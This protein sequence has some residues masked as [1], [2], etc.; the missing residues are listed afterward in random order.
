MGVDEI[1]S[2]RI[3]PAIGIARI[4]NSPDEY[5]I[6]PEL[7]YPVAAPPGGY[8]DP[9]GRLKRQAAQ[10]RIYGYDADGNVVAEITVADAEIAWTVHVANTK[11]AWYDFNFALDLFPIDTPVSMGAVMPDRPLRAGSPWRA[12]C[13]S[14]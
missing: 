9:Q 10:F 11:S 3:H 12:A 2:A 5:F 7:P 1:V 4:G 14:S 8:K 6:G 13:T